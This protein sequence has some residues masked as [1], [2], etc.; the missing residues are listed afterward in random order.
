VDAARPGGR[1][2]PYGTRL[3][4]GRP[5]W[6]AQ[7]ILWHDAEGTK[8]VPERA[9]N[10]VRAQEGYRTGRV[11]RTLQARDA[12][13]TPEGGLSVSE[14]KAPI[15]RAGFCALGAVLSKGVSCRFCKM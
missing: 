4:F 5:A 14:G 1:P 2:S 12:G 10:D 6:V 3:Q 7:R 9:H 11:L 13:H 15:E 8:W